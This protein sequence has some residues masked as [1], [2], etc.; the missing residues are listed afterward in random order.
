M[1]KI[2]L[3]LTAALTVPAVVTASAMPAA[4]A[5]Y[6]L[7]VLNPQGPVDRVKDLA[8]RLGTLQGKRIAMWLSAT[9]DQLFAGKGT[10]LFDQL[11]KMLRDTYPNIDIVPYKDLP[12][13]FAP[14]NE[15][16]EKI[17][18]ARPDGVVAGF[19]G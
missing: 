10:E 18:A 3:L 7:T 15:V 11:E 16:V 12:M 4:A 5:D 17:V 13:K 6:S 9:P 19:G 2:L 1:K 14:E 8:P